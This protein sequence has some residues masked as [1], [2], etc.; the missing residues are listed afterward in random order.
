MP[1]KVTGAASKGFEVE[2]MP[3]ESGMAIVIILVTGI[4]FLLSI[5]DLPFYNCYIE[6]ENN[7]Y[8]VFLEIVCIIID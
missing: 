6:T 8:S 5:Y 4:C 3:T 2:Y 7:V 1:V